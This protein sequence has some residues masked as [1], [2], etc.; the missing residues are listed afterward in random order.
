MGPRGGGGGGGDYVK[1]YFH[2]IL[3]HACL[4]FNQ[5]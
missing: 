4:D 2:L 1:S 5:A 3:Q